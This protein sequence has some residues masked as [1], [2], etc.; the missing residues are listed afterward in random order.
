MREAY[1]A[2]VVGS[3]PNGLGAAIALA[4]AGLAVLVLEAEPTIGG[5]ARS[6][7]LTRPGFV[8][9][10]CSAI[11]PLAVASPFFRSLPLAEHGLEWIEPPAA[12][13]HP[14]DDGTAILLERSVGET[15]RHLGTDEAAYRRLMEPLVET[16]E[17]LFFDVLGPLRWPRHWGAAL[18]FGW[19]ALR[20]AEGLVRRHFTAE[21]AKALFGGMAGHSGLRLEQSPSAAFGL[22]LA[23]A[24]HAVGWPLPRGGR[25]GSPRPLRRICVHWEGRFGRTI[26]SHRSMTFRRR[27]PCCST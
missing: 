21:R 19:Q 2:V 24:G 18:R 17:S 15:A 25:S 8:H 22:V 9:D 6:A 12:L 7:E 13:A 16:A 14:L 20:S 27:G 11:H 4:R 3:G 10:L 26:V 5:G 23:V 1:D